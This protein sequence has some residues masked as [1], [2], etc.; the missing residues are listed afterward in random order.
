MT[1]DKQINVSVPEGYSGTP[2]EIV[3]REGSAQQINN[4]VPFSFNG[5]ID[6]VRR[7]LEGQLIPTVHTVVIFDSEAKQIQA[8]IDYGHEVCGLI[9]SKVEYSQPMLVFGVNQDKRFTLDGLRKLVRLQR[10]YF[11]DA[12]EHAQLLLKLE[13]FTAKVN[14]LITD[15]RNNRGNLKKEL[16]R[17]VDADIP[18]QFKLSLPVFKGA[19]RYPFL[20]DVC[21]DVADS[22]VTFWLES[23]Q[24]LEYESSQITTMFDTQ[25]EMIQ[26]M[27][28]TCIVKS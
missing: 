5:N 7:F 19:G 11:A 6:A 24:L 1:T 21:M 4:K 20:V 17:S 25:R 9:F 8:T 10:V 26:K 2:I 16:S 18:F 3:L 12:D 22:G 23:A 27:G 14:T 15:E 13:G 28:Y